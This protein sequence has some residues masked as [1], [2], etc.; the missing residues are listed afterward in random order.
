M[1]YKSH[2]IILNTQYAILS[3]RFET[4]QTQYYQKITQKKLNPLI[5]LQLDPSDRTNFDSSRQS[6]LIL[7]FP[8]FEGTMCN[9]LKSVC[10]AC[11]QKQ[12]NKQNTKKQKNK[13]TYNYE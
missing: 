6:P 5:L 13:C 12:R 7:L 4:K 9:L 11:V 3:F 2:V 10:S 1:I 8:L